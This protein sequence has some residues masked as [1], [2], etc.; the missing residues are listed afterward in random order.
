MDE[1]QKL[2]AEIASRLAAGHYANNTG[3]G[4]KEIAQRALDLLEAVEALVPEERHI[5]S[6]RVG[7]E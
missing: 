6:H 2:V 7:I 4:A 3:W 5:S 1:R